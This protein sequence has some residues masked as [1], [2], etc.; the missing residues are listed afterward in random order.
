MDLKP[1]PHPWEDAV[2]EKRRRVWHNDPTA[3]LHW[4]PCWRRYPNGDR[5]PTLILAIID[6]VDEWRR[7]NSVMRFGCA[8]FVDGRCVFRGYLSEEQVR[9]LEAKGG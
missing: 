3:K 2:Q 5:S 6:E 7:F 9:E 8:Q 4:V 1:P